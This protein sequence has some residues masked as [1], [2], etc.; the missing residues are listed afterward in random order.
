MWLENLWISPFSYGSLEKFKQDAEWFVY[1]GSDELLKK[2]RS[3][4][5]NRLTE[6]KNIAP[7]AAI[8]MFEKLELK[9]AIASKWLSFLRKTIDC[10]DFF[11]P[12]ESCN[13]DKLNSLT[14]A[15]T[16][17]KILDSRK[18]VVA[19]SDGEIGQWVQSFLYHHIVM[20]NGTSGAIGGS[21]SYAMAVKLTHPQKDV[22]AF[23]GDGT[24]GFSSC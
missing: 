16:I 22:L 3:N 12:D 21:L 23:M 2:A 8:D 19:I 9:K 14:F 6:G 13:Q 24:I 11:I 7:L 10:R 20:I 1:I 4:L 17:N 5:G 15:L 18:D